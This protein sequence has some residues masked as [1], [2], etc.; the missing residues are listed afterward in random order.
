MDAH[1]LEKLRHAS[2]WPSRPNGSST[3]GRQQ[4][5]GASSTHY[6][7]LG[8]GAGASAEGIRAAYLRAAA[9]THP[10]RPGG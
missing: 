1:R 8:V 3:S 4:Q 9:L 7:V 10:D 6:T 2:W 5:P